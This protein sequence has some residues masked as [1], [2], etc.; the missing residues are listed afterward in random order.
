MSG[1]QLNL[2][3]LGER[4]GRLS[5][6]R[7]S[8]SP[9]TKKSTSRMHLSVE[10]LKK[11]PRSNSC[12]LASLNTSRAS[13]KRRKESALKRE[14]HTPRMTSKHGSRSKIHQVATARRLAETGIGR[15]AAPVVNGPAV[16][17]TGVVSVGGS[18]T[19]RADLSSAPRLVNPRSGRKSEGRERNGEEAVMRESGTN[20]EVIEERS[21]VNSAADYASNAVK[22][23]QYLHKCIEQTIQNSAP[24]NTVLKIL[25]ECIM[26]TSGLLKAVS[27]LPEVA[28]MLERDTKDLCN[29]RQSAVN[30]YPD[31]NLILISLIR[32]TAVAERLLPVSPASS[33]PLQSP[34]SSPPL[35]PFPLVGSEGKS[36]K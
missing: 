30:A 20:V 18:R 32:I 13:P 34:S 35:Q 27:D 36:S 22:E 31:L 7:D 10:D 12:E 1:L 21:I 4:D 26:Q 16:N 8:P 14:S 2:A 33:P 19:H 6:H 15:R 25:D 28:A 5:T 11:T 3:G 29:I 17:G 24:A 9:S 23:L